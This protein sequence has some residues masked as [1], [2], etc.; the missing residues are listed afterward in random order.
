MSG[1]PALAE[2]YQEMAAKIEWRAR[3]KTAGMGDHLGI[4]ICQPHRQQ[5]VP[6]GDRHC[7]YDRRGQQVDAAEGGHLLHEPGFGPGKDKSPLE[8]KSGGKTDRLRNN[9]GK[10]KAKNSG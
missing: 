3:R 10:L 8:K 4:E 5:G 6:Q 1:K 7:D 9:N 2:R